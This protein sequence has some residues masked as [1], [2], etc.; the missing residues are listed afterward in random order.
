M[1]DAAAIAASEPA[2]ETWTRYDAPE[3]GYPDLVETLG[4]E[5][6][7]LAAHIHAGTHR[8]LTL[9]A[10]FDRLRAVSLG[11]NGVRLLVQPPPGADDWER[12]LRLRDAGFAH[13]SLPAA[14]FAP[15]RTVVQYFDVR[16]RSAAASL[17]EALG[18]DVVDLT[19]FKPRPADRR[20]EVYLAD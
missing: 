6:A 8:L 14:R 12:D 9:L 18:G 13:E 19:K 4:D 1:R 7:T 3:P 16:D 10:R 17:A 11:F 20:V 5:I 15:P 2:E